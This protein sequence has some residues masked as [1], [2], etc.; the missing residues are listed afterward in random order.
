MDESI[1]DSYI[2]DSFKESEV[3]EEPPITYSQRKSTHVMEE[4]I[5]GSVAV[6]E[7]AKNSHIESQ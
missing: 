1:K 7:T 3:D 6:P 5:H 4:S 2:N